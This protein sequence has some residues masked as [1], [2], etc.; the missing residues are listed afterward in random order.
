MNLIM[1]AQ[2]LGGE[3][4]P[5]RNSVLCP[6]PGH[7]ATDR[8]LN[9]TFSG[10]DFVVYSHANDSFAECRDYVKSRLGLPSNWKPAANSFEVNPEDKQADDE[11]RLKLVLR[12]WDK[13]RPIRSTLA[14]TYLNSR[15]CYVEGVHDLRFDPNCYYA[16]DDYRPAM[17]GLFRDIITGEPCGL[18]RTFLNADGSKFDRKMLGR[19]MGAAIKLIPDF[20]VTYGL[21]LGEGVESTLSGIILGYSPAWVMGSGVNLSAFPAVSD[22]ETITVFLENDA[23]G[24]NEKYV[25]TMAERLKL[26]GMSIRGRK[27]KTGNDLNDELRD[28]LGIQWRKSTESV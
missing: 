25:R 3:A 16:K 13:T 20:D 18:H 11:K 7:S 5:S 15:G 23:N 28:A 17:I 12:I 1:A 26:Q 8:S 6:G 27:P 14:E 4:T 19:H 10:D 21:S 9:V 24:A 22:I 2:L